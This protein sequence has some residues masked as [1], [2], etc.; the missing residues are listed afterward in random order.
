MAMWSMTACDKYPGGLPGAA[1]SN[2]LPLIKRAE[3]RNSDSRGPNNAVLAHS[4]H[5][6]L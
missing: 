1:A 5:D 3:L 2:R 6:L 4:S